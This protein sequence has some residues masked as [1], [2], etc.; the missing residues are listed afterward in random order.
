MTTTEGVYVDGKLTTP[1]DMTGPTGATMVLR[2]PTVD[3]AVMETARGGLVKRGM[4]YDQCD[5]A[6]C[7]NIDADHLGSN[8]VDTLED[9]ARVKRTVVEVATGTAV[10]NADDQHCLKMAA[11]TRASRLCYV[12]MNPQ[13]SLVREHIRSGGMAV[14]L[15]Q[16]LN[17]H[18][19]SIYDNGA[20][21]PLVWTHLIPATIEGRAMHNVQNAMFAAGLAYGMGVS[22]ENIEHG[23]RTF[24]TSFFQAPGRMNVFDEHP[25]KVIMDYGHNAAGVA[26]VSQMADGFTIAGRKIVVLA[27]PGDRRDEDVVAIAEAAAGHF[28]HYICRR[29]DRLRGRGE[30]EVPEML[31]DALM[32]NGVSEDQIELIPDEQ[33]AVDAALTMGRPG[34]MVIVFADA[35]I[36]SWK[37]IIYFTPEGAEEADTATTTTTVPALVSLP[38]QQAWSE[39]AE[40][41]VISDER[42]VWLAKDEEGD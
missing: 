19:I 6:A 11:Y 37:Q 7:L 14:V 28:D 5:V 39:D 25:F 8:G 27:A 33:Q 21:T 35:L 17:G 1:G 24:T 3:A 15:E 9:L 2:D 23:L 12:T 22:R 31:R 20:H 32:A 13:H 18:M 10:L 4:G 29:D 38:A 16:G 26:A 34:D 36:R 42:G 30:N 40:V 41:E